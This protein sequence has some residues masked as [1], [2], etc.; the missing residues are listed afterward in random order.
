MCF[1]GRITR[2]TRRS[3]LPCGLT[4]NWIARIR[5]SNLSQGMDVRLC[6]TQIKT[7]MSCR[8]NAGAT[9]LCR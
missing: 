8:H 4:H 2:F 6:F 7:A 3:Q 9:I 1:R 5:G